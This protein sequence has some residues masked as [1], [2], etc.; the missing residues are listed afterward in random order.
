LFIVSDKVSGE[1]TEYLA[2]LSKVFFIK[3]TIR[4]TATAIYFLLSCLSI[5]KT[6]RRSVFQFPCLTARTL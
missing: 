1:S 5:A 4:R 2:E 6:A 3:M